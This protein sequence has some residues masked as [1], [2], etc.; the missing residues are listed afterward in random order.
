LLNL[1]SYTYCLD[2]TIGQTLGYVNASINLITA[3]VD[4]DVVIS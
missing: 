3:A 4:I 2:T 1:T